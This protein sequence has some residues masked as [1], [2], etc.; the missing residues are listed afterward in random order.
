MCEM[1]PPI[2]KS[3]LANSLS[4]NESSLRGRRGDCSKLLLFHF[5][6]RVCEKCTIGSDLMSRGAFLKSERST[7]TDPVAVH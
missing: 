6:A 1:H 5:S 4:V 3:I 2:S 7:S